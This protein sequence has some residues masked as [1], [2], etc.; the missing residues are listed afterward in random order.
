MVD[1]EVVLA[2]SSMCT[3][4]GHQL[5]SLVFPEIDRL[6]QGQLIGIKFR[7]KAIERLQDNCEVPRAC[8]D[9]TPR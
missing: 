1:L 9:R 8:V 7:V 2:V 3:E 6:I 5:T 4:P